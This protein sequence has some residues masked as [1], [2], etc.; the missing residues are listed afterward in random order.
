MP[1]RV[2]CGYLETSLN[3]PA[4]S[5]SVVNLTAAA[6]NCDVSV[7]QMLS[8]LDVRTGTQWESMAGIQ[9]KRRPRKEQF[10]AA[11]K[12]EE[13]VIDP[14]TDIK[15]WH[16]R[17]VLLEFLLTVC[18]VD[19]TRLTKML[20]SACNALITAEPDL[21]RWDT[22]MG[23]GDCGETL[24]TGAT[25]LLSNVDSLAESGSVIKVLHEVESIVESKMGGTLGGILGIFFVALTSGLQRNASETHAKPEQLWAKALSHALSNLQQATPAKTGDRT[26]MDV[27]IPF[28][29]SLKATENFSDAVESAQKAAESTKQMVPKLG[30]ATYVGHA[31]GTEM[32]PDPGAWGAMEAIKGLYDGS[33]S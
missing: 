12:E 5:T 2:Y 31:E 21:T 32:P 33:K 28:V 30:R 27:L 23:D 20:K 7:D 17:N 14:K 15:G 10:V 4:F 16:E 25:A 11:P 1:V 19:P 13:R 3:A 6:K 8:Y 26:V 29:E 22:V 9:A 24:K 18:A